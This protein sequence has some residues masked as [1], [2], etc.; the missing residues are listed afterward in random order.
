VRG[1]TL[2]P[3]D[4]VLVKNLSER[5]GPGKLRAYWEKVVHSVVERLGDGP[6]YK[7]QPER[8]SKSL[9]VLHRNL[10][11]PV[12][13]LPLEEDLPVEEKTRPKRQTNRK[14]QQTS[15]RYLG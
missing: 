15:N 14:R 3:G 11:L 5:G 8:G 1:V 2:Q 7:V 6:V 9:R 4:R 10:L 13:D 12:N